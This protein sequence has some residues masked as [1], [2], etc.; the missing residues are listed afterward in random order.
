[1]SSRNIFK[2]LWLGNVF[3][4]SKG[5]ICGDVLCGD[6]PWEGAR[7]LEESGKPH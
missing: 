7:E 2:G 5:I 3:D 6:V 1:M 4:H